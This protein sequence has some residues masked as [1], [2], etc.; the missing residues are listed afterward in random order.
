MSNAKGTRYESVLAQFLQENGFPYAERRAKKGVHD[1]GDMAGIPGIVLE[2][3]SHKSLSLPQWL[4]EARV[5]Q[6]RDKADYGIVVAR[7]RN[8]WIGKSYFAMDLIQGLHLLRQAGYG[9]PMLGDE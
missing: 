7:R 8:H 1:T 9:E 3:K 4:D 5:E 2:A 6:E